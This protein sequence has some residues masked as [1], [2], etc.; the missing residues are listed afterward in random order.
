MLQLQQTAKQDSSELRLATI[1][2]ARTSGALGTSL[3]EYAKLGVVSDGQI[4]TVHSPAKKSTCLY[5]KVQTLVLTTSRIQY[6]SYAARSAISI[7]K[8]VQQVEMLYVLP[9]VN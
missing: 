9:K 2:Q 7:L 4:L 6:V 1:H 5:T 3:Q 8:S